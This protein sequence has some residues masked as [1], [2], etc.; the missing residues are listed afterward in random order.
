MENFDRLILASDIITGI[1]YLSLLIIVFQI[2]KIIRLRLSFFLLA[3]G[4]LLFVNALLY[5]LELYDLITAN[6]SISLIIR[7]STA[8]AAFAAAVFFAISKSE[9]IKIVRQAQASRQKDLELREAYLEMEKRVEDRTTDLMDLNK[10]LTLSEE[11]YRNTF[12]LA[13]IGV[14]HVNTDG[15]VI[16]ANPWLCRILGYQENEL[17]GMDAQSFVHPDDLQVSIE[18]FESALVG[19]AS[20]YFHEAR[21]RNKTGDYI[22]TRCAITLMRD[23]E[24]KATFVIV[25]EDTTAQRQ[26]ER[27]LRESEFRLRRLMDA[28]I[29]GVSYFDS[30]SGTIW[31]ANH[32]FLR[33][34]GFT[35]ED[36]RQGKITWRDMTPP[37]WIEADNK[38]MKDYYEKGSFAPFEK[39]YIR[40]DG[41]RLPVLVGA[42]RLPE[43]GDRGVGFALDLTELKLTQKNLEETESRFKLIIETIPNLVWMAKPNGDNVFFNKGWHDYTGLT[44]DESKGAGW[45]KTVHPEDLE[46]MLTAKNSW[47]DAI[48]KGSEYAT[49]YRV[50]SKTGEYR[51]H[52][53]RALPLRDDRG[54]T[55]FWFGTCTDIHDQKIAEEEL[56]KS[57]EQLEKVIENRTHDLQQ[58]NQAL[59]ATNNELEAFCYSISHDLRAPLRGIDGFT[60]ALAEDYAPKLDDQ[61]SRYITFVRQ[62]VKRMGQMIDDLLN[63][64]RYS[65]AEFHKKETNLSQIAEKIIERFR[66]EDPTRIV[67]F[68]CVPNMS[69]NVDAGLMTSA[70]ENLLS[71]A[72]KFTKNVP[73]AKIEFG[74]RGNPPERK[75]FIKDN[76]EGF[77]SR[78]VDKLFGAFQRLHSSDDFEGTGIGLAIC[79]RIIT[80]HGGKIWAESTPKKGATFYFTL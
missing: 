12:D 63:L 7:F 20:H 42:T 24:G 47:Y 78:Y 26:A 33:M 57:Q 36:L 32:E 62:S 66:T 50:R 75:Y 35:P 55:V 77:D 13:A 80:R 79:R 60:Q 41:S 37:E 43:E 2:F 51:W 11:K 21:Y 15:K 5:F 61:A 27:S 28:N 25:L 22:W 31:E 45:R 19:E 30:A 76:G 54:A 9:V 16:M 48:R 53:V 67:D 52:L 34:L 4:V 49:Q 38:A 23:H 58:A 73:R 71:N 44:F 17:I 29:L 74:Y 46:Q 56:K 64:S 68:L 39:E 8:L 70:L 1:A 59:S 10:A 72:W 18:R 3:F 69:A 14:A 6:Y 65:R 40:R